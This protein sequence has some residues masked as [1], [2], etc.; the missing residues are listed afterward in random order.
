MTSKRAWETYPPTYRAREMDILA[1]WIQA[2]GHGKSQRT[3]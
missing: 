1:R 3:S 2:G